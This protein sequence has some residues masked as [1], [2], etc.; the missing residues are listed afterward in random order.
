M[1]LSAGKNKCTENASTNA[2]T[3]SY[4]NFV[5]LGSFGGPSQGIPRVELGVVVDAGVV[6]NAQ[7]SFGEM[8][9]RGASQNAAKCSFAAFFDAPLPPSLRKRIA[10]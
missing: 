2:P 8:G 9:G 6:V 10:H 5:D 1:A 7:F 3:N 4:V